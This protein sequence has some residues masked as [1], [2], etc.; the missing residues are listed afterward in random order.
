MRKMK[1]IY[2]AELIANAQA[3]RKSMTR[4]E[5][6]PWYDCLK[7]L[8]IAFHRQK[9]IGNHIVDFYC[10]GAKL[11][12]EID[13]SQHYDEENIGKDRIRDEYLHGLGWQ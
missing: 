3:L 11:V 7:K 10:A 1:S 2:H 12:I 5:R 9:V 6:Q 4:E 8:P 13:G